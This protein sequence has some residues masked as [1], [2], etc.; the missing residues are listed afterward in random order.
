MAGSGRYPVSGC[1]R[2]G[3]NKQRTARL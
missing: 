1:L 3:A 2:L